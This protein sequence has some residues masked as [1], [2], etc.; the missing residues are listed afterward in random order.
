MS[1][2]AVILKRFNRTLK[3]K[4]N[5]WVYG[6]T[7]DLQAAIDRMVAA[8]NDTPH[9]ALKNVSPNDVYAGREGRGVGPAGQDQARDDGSALCLQ[10]GH[11]RRNRKLIQAK[12]FPK[13][14]EDVH[15]QFRATVAISGR[16]RTPRVRGGF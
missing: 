7:E 11:G 14:A 1:R 9:E 8:Y 3:E 16:G 4:V 12:K 5:L 15:G 2:I 6:T 10:Y 13:I